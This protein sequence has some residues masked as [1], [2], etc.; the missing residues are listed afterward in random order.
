[1]KTQTKSVYYCDHCKKNGLSKH[2]MEQHE[3]QCSRNPAN[4]HPCF[5]CKHFEIS[6]ESH[7]QHYEGGGNDLTRWV[8]SDLWQCKERGIYLHTRRAE[9]KNLLTKYPESFIDTELMPSEC[10][11]YSQKTIDEE[12]I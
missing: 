6:T 2:K 4:F 9:V 7:E 8:E 12:F 10:E 3:N 1:M 5:D 11:L